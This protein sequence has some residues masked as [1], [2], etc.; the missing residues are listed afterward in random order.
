MNNSILNQIQ[1]VVFWYVNQIVVNGYQKKK[2]KT[3]SYQFVTPPAQRA[4]H[5]TQPTKPKRLPRPSTRPY[6]FHHITIILFCVAIRFLFFLVQ[7]GFPPELSF[8]SNKCMY[9]Y[10]FSIY[11]YAIFLV[12][13]LSSSSS[14]FIL[15][16]SFMPGQTHNEST[17]KILWPLSQ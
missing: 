7:N 11:L 1:I 12:L 9:V 8:I 13:F 17:L 6:N 4:F 5:K 3:K 15:I 2:E 16:R 10:L 14:F